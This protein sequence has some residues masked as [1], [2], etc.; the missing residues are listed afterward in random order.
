[1]ELARDVGKSLEERHEIEAGIE[2]RNKEKDRLR[3]Q[4][5]ETVGREADGPEDLLRFEMWK[6]QNGRCLYTDTEI[7]P[8]A[9]VS[10]DNRVQVD[11]ILPWSRSGDN[12]FVNKTLCYA[13]ANQDKKGRTPFEWFGPDADRWQAFT[14]AVEGCREM[15]GRKSATFF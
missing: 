10:T 7:H 13:K 8:D 4:F 11:H 2:K 14:S 12:S 9:I 3:L 5:V 15:K 6:E 1:M